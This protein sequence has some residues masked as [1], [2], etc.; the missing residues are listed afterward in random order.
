MRKNQSMTHRRLPPLNA[1]KAFEAAARHQSVTLAAKELNVTQGAV[2][3]QVKALEGELGIPLFKRLHRRIVL[4]DAGRELLPHLSEVFDRIADVTR[5]LTRTQHELTLRVQPTFALRWLIPRMQQFQNAHAEMQIRLM[6]ESQSVDFRADDIDAAI[7]YGEIKQP[8][9]QQEPIHKERVTPVCAPGLLEG[10]RPL[11]IPEDLRHHRLLLN[12]KE[13]REWLAWTA[14]AGVDNLPLD[15]GQVFDTD[16]A[17]FQAAAAG[18]GVALGDKLLI[19]DDLKNGRLVAPFPDIAAETG[20]Y[21]FATTAT[22]PV[23]AVTLTFKKWL[24]VELT[25]NE[26]DA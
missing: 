26:S 9:I 17:A 5:R 25:P 11:S 22:R 19:D 3:R 10:P 7:V 24:M 21:Y 15:H 12:S 23:S 2:S 16:D 6:I 14:V 1:L 4:T 13:Q 8:G 18:L 20:V